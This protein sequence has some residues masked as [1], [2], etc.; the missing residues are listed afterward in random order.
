M[1]KKISLTLIAICSIT[2]TQAQLYIGV[3][4]GINNTKLYNSSDAA[5]DERQDYV[6]TL[7]PQFGITVG[8]KANDKISLELQPQ[9][10]TLGQKYKGTYTEFLLNSY[11]YDATLNLYYAKLPLFLKYTF[12]K[13]YTKLSYHV[14]AGANIGYLVKYVEQYSYQHNPSSINNFLVS[15]EVKNNNST[16]DYSQ[17]Y[18]VAG[19]NVA[20]P[21]KAILDKSLYNKLNLGVN[22]GLGFNLHVNSKLSIQG[23]IIGEYGLMNIE[24]TDTINY[25]DASTNISIGTTQSSNLKHAKYILSPKLTDAKR[26]TYTNGRAIGLQ[27]GLIYILGNKEANMPKKM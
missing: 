14:L 15:S 1:I 10:F 23:N 7:K 12:S 5:A 18:I 11:S 24:N 4:T 16:V 6:M 19:Q 17:T 20:N 8:Y 3:N 13:P 22:L 2:A 25:L 21:A 26:N 9:L 27:L